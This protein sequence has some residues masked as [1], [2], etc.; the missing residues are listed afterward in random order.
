M[1][2]GNTARPESAVIP[3]MEERGISRAEF[4]GFYSPR[5]RLRAERSALSN[6]VIPMPRAVSGTSA[7]GGPASGGKDLGLAPHILLCHPFPSMSPLHNS[8]RITA[9]WLVRS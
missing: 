7:F 5:A 1:G 6:H 3:P 9:D 4:G 8:P 2:R